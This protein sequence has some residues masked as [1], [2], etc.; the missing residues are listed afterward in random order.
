MATDTYIYSTT[1]SMLTCGNCSI[2]FAIPDDLHRKVKRDGS[3]FWCPNGHNISYSET[4]NQRLKAERDSLKRD[5]DWAETA[6]IAARD[7]ADAA[8][9]RRRAAQ[10]QVTKMRKRI[11]NGVC[12]CC[13]RTFANVSAHM[14]TKHPGFAADDREAG[15]VP[16]S[17]SEVRAWARRNNIEV[18]VKGRIPA[19]VRERYDR[20]HPGA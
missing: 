7:Q 4:E 9:R 20:E 1:L 16:A 19:S 14:E 8:E 3:P 15:H 13:N 12:P 5:F 17:S 10:G 6:R 11:G 2:P 18:G